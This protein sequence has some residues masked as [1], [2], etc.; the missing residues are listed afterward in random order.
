MIITKSEIMEEF[1]SYLTLMKKITEEE[2][3]SYSISK[4]AKEIAENIKNNK[5]VILT[6]GEAKSGKS[7]FINAFLGEEILPMDVK[8]CTSSI[9]EISHGEQPELII[10]YADGRK[11]KVTTSTTE[12]KKSLEKGAFKD[13]HREIPIDLINNKLLIEKKGKISDDEIEKF[14]TECEEENLYNLPSEE[15][16]RK[17][18]EYVQENKNNWQNIIISLELKW[19]LNEKYKNIVIVDSSGVHAIG[20]VGGITENYMKKADAILFVKSS[21]EQAIEST[22]FHKFL[23]EVTTSEHKDS[24]FLVMS[25]EADI[26]KSDLN[27]IFYDSDRIYEKIDDWKKIAVDSRIELIINE[28]E[29]KSYK[30]IKDYFRKSE[31]EGT[32]SK[33]AKDLWSESKGNVEEYEKKMKELSN[34]EELRNTLDIFVTGIKKI[35]VGRLKEMLVSEYNEVMGDFEK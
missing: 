7:T 17:I 6:V 32:V 9:I 10:T 18:Y 27:R 16:K 33:V 29:N 1:N 13:E 35:A 28:C 8:Q 30:E 21:V 34:F 14:C 5:F 20:G 26:S 12:I 4:E 22:S 15:Y 24:I 31:K 23:N 19:R 3:I 11:E 25:G 2:S